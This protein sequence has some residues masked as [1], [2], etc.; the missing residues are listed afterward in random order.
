METKR[1]YSITE[2]TS[3]SVLSV[4][5]QQLATALLRMSDKT[6]TKR[7]SEAIDLLQQLLLVLDKDSFDLEKTLNIT[8]DIVYAYTKMHDFPLAEHY[9]SLATA[10]VTARSYSMVPIDILEQRIKYHNGL[11]VKEKG[12]LRLAAEI[13]TECV[14]G[15][16]I[17]D[18]NVR[19]KSLVEL[20]D[21][22]DQRKIQSVEL[23]E[24]LE[25]FEIEHKDIVFLLDYSESMGRQGRIQKAKNHILNIFTRFVENEDRVAFITFN[26]ECHIAFNLTAKG[27]NTEFLRKQVEKWSNPSGQTAFY[28]AVA[29]ALNEFTAYS[30]RMEYESELLDLGEEWR[31]KREKRAQWILAL[32][33]GEDTGS[34]I[35]YKR[36]KTELEYVLNRHSKASLVTIGLAL[37]ADIKRVIETLCTSTRKGVYIDSENC[38]QLDAA[39]QQ[40]SAL[41]APLDV[42]I[43]SLLVDSNP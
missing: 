24:L 2:E 16:R 39:F 10:K 36:L 40:L 42:T 6:P 26:K 35:S 19:C 38:D 22:F 11:I 4:R 30:E 41:I 3:E 12:D 21:I 31:E 1:A 15:N 7:W 23:N 33:D 34:D 8:L 20:K 17:Y 14:E 32:T 27:Q 5:M 25:D 18:P 28:D 9:L 37:P 13:F 29:V 43:E